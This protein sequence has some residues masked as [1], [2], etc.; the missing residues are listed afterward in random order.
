[1]TDGPHHLI[2][3]AYNHECLATCPVMA[4]EQLIAVESAL[5]WDMA[6]GYLLPSISCD[7]EGKA[8]IRANALISAAE[9]TH[10]LKSHAPAA[11]E[12]ANLSIHP[13]CSGGSNR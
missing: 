1:M 5:G 3:V 11:G 10:A 13:I 7:A 6:R 4:V 8:F 9:M 2:S 12:K